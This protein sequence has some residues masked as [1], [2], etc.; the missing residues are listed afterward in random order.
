MIYLIYLH[1]VICTGA[2]YSRSY[3]IDEK[4]KIIGPIIFALL[5]PISLPIAVFAIEG[6]PWYRPAK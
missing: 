6:P 1:V 5:W 2:I 3:R 4:N